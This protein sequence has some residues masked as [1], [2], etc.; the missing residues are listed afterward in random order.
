MKGNN[1]EN[2]VQLDTHYTRSINL[3]RDAN[4]SDILKAYI[5]TSRA[6][7]TLDK[8]ADTFN[9]K[10]IPRAW[11]LVGPYGSGKSS[12]AAFLSHLLEDQNLETNLTAEDILQRYNA[13]PYTQV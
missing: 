6:I 4:S 3:E 1:L 10:N 12:F 7:Q 5:P 2:I 13:S 8:I 11:S 9:D